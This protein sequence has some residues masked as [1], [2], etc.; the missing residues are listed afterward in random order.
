MDC[1]C[2]RLFQR[3]VAQLEREVLTQVLKHTGGNKAKAARLLRVDYKTMHMK[4]K[5][6]GIRV[7]EELRDISYGK[8]NQEAS[9][10][11]E[12]FEAPEDFDLSYEVPLNS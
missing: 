1:P 5:K 4:L 2:G 12:V 8:E 3:G 6:L 9:L 10:E 7:R 11:P